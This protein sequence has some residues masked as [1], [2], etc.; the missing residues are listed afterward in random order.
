MTNLLLIIIE[1]LVCFFGIVL[2][3]KL[4]GKEGLIAWIAIASILAN[5]LTAKGV[6]IFGLDYTLG[7]VLF[8][9]TFLATDILTE[10]Y[11]K[12]VATKGVYVGLIATLSLI[13]FSQ[14]GL[15]YIPAA[16]SLEIQGALETLFAL[17]LRVSISSL[18]MYFI[19]N[20]LDIYIYDYFRKK[21]KG[22]HK[23]AR[24][25]IATVVCNGLENFLF[26]FGAFIGVPGFTIKTIIL[27]AL[28]TS[29]IE[30][31]VALLDTPFLYLA[32]TKKDKLKISEGETE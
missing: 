20:L 1:I 15:K 4:L 22:K 27:M 10:M 28:T 2:I 13:I 23:W 21:T 14:L 25:N 3:S 11:G 31:I 18:V 17:S 30:I 29:L 26:M 12:K 9:S 19:A 16:F 8:A 32:T 24:N 6:V 5:I 7:T